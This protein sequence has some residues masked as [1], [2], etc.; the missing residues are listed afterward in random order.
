LL[1]VTSFARIGFVSQLLPHSPVL[2]DMQFTLPAALL[3]S[4]GLI[5]VVYALKKPQALPATARQ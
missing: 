5:A 2:R 1:A 3:L 4:A